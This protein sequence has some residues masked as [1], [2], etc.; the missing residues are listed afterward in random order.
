ML[1]LNLELELADSTHERVDS[2]GGFKVES[3]TSNSSVVNADALS[4]C[5]DGEDDSCST[6]AVTF[7]FEILKGKGEE[8]EEEEEEGP[9]SW[10]HSSKS[11]VDISFLGG[12]GSSGRDR[13]VEKPSL[14]V[15]KSRRGPRSKSSQYRGVTFYRR[16]GRWESHI[17]DCGK[18]VYLGGFDTAH[19][20]ARAY[21]RAAVKFRGPE[22]DINFTI[23]DYEEDIKKLANLSK[24]EVVQ[25]LRRQ[26]NG[27]SRG[28]S[29]YQGIALNN[30]GAWGTQMDLFLGKRVCDKEG[31]KWNG[32]EATS[33]FV[34]HA[35]QMILKAHNIADDKLD[36]NLRV[37]LP[38]GDGPKQKDRCFQLNHAP[39]D[40]VSERNSKTCLLD[41]SLISSLI[42]DFIAFDP[43]SQ[44]GNHLAAVSCD[45]PFNFLKRGLDHPITQDDLPTPFFSLKERRQEK[46]PLSLSLQSSRTWQMQDQA[47]GGLIKAATTQ[48]LFTNA[49]SSGFP[50]SASSTSLQHPSQ[51]SL[52]FIHS[53]DNTPQQYHHHNPQPPP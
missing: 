25:V 32:K 15:K 44:M 35:S 30:F 17:W 43:C 7:H 18:Q 37:S 28:N 29:R 20:A 21:D 3:V 41:I 5:I 34:P 47:D 36:L 27:F 22:A 26:S 31:I 13:V 53:Y 11:S 38:S 6:R 2:A 46:G 40:I 8:E 4:S 19:A 1:D 39:N 24:E 23:S 42:H 52:Y 50:F 16:T 51:P 49:A 10:A 9:S 33:K 12:G 14:P 45:P 48:P